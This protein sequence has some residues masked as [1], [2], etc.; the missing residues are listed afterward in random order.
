MSIIAS[1]KKASDTQQQ[2]LSSPLQASLITREINGT[3]ENGL[4]EV[5]DLD[6]NI[7][8][9]SLFNDIKNDEWL[10]S[11]AVEAID[12]SERW[13]GPIHSDDYQAHLPPSVDKAHAAK[14][15]LEKLLFPPH[16]SGPGHKCAKLDV[17]LSHRLQFMQSLLSIYTDPIH[18]KGWTKASKDA[19]RIFDMAH[20][21]HTSAEWAS[22]QLCKWTKDF[23]Q[24]HSILPTTNYRSGNRSLIEDKDLKHDLLLYLQEIS[25]YVRAMDVVNYM[26]TEEVK[27]TYRL[28]TGISLATAKHWMHHLGYQWGKTPTGQY[29]NG[30]ERK[31][32][33][34][35]RNDVFIPSWLQLQGQMHAWE[36]ENL[37]ID[38]I[39]ESGRQVVVWH[40]NESIFYS[41][42]R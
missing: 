10:G 37:T 29:V 36:G 39:S 26:N 31:D 23:V 33:V 11:N 3:D 5:N 35:Y 25:K 24:D 30:H 40:H 17:H 7:D 6:D 9:E 21:A 28:R 32:V 38:H 2:Q 1:S 14:D 20:R 15:N 13:I 19:I 4:N 22:C 18:G 27:N 8:P 41:N 16:D 12:D 34:K 42:D